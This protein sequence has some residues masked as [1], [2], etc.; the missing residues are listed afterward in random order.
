MNLG[1]KSLEASIAELEALRNGLAKRSAVGDEI[2]LIP[3]GINALA[4]HLT[5]Q[6][7]AAAGTVTAF[8]GLRGK[9]CAAIGRH[10]SAQVDAQQIFFRLRLLLVTSTLVAI[11]FMPVHGKRDK[12][13]QMPY[14][15]RQHYKGSKY[16]KT[17]PE[18]AE[19]ALRYGRSAVVRGGREAESV[20]VAAAGVQ[21]RAAQLC[22]PVPPSWRQGLPPGLG[23]ARY[24]DTASVSAPRERTN[25][26]RQSSI[27]WLSNAL[28]KMPPITAARDSA[29]AA[30]SDIAGVER[31][32]P[33]SAGASAV[34]NANRAVCPMHRMHC[35][36][37]GFSPARDAALHTSHGVGAYSILAARAGL[38]VPTD[39][40]R[41]RLQNIVNTPISD[42]EYDVWAEVLLDTV[43]ADVR[44]G[45]APHLGVLFGTHNW[46]SCEK[47]FAEVVHPDQSLADLGRGSLCAS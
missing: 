6:R 27:S 47:I 42:M 40:T 28:L 41:L 11:A 3:S 35:Q 22:R 36:P 29:T 20:A 4:K 13:C 12:V 15:I 38:R 37:P 23:T 39:A 30:A 7:K 8:P 16:E 45:G 1:S 24:R 26:G 32:P 17:I 18:E 2:L 9:G 44:A 46:A 19:A 25:P 43:A 14:Y 5:G 21:H 10:T 33:R 31:T 34:L